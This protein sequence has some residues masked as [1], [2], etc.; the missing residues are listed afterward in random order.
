[1]SERLRVLFLDEGVLGHRT[2]TAQLQATL[3]DNAAVETTFATV[4]PPNK[5]ERLLLRRWRR[6]GDADMFALRW[7]LRWSWRVRRLLKRHRRSVDVA[8]ISTQASALLI[9]GPM[10]RLPC[11]LSIDATVGQFTALEYGG[12][13][14]TWT[15]R[16]QRLL[17][18]L[19]RRALRGAA[20]VVPWTGWNEAALRREYDMSEVRLAT[21]HPGLDGTWWGRAAAARP[22]RDGGPLRVLFVGNE[23]ERKGL[24]TLIDA[25]GRL[26][27]EAILDVVSTDPVPE[28]DLV[29]PHRNVKARTE[30]LRDLYAA[31]DVLALPTRADAVPWVVL[32]AMAAGLPV[33]ASEVGAIGELLGGSGELVQPDDPEQLAAALRRL[34][35]PERR[36]RLG[37]R[38]LERVREN[39][40]SPVQVQRLLE[41]LEE[42]AGRSASAQG[43]GRGRIRRRT[44]VAV[45]AGVVAVAVVAPYAALIPDDE[46]EK[47]VASNLGID[48]KLA[49]QLLARARA[50][51]GDTE[52]DARATAFALAVRDPA[53]IV[54]PDSTREKAISGLLD[55]MLDAPAA[56]LAY[57]ITGADPG[58]PGACAGLVRES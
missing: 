54:L 52:Y 8:F 44:F 19:E 22:A 16:Q 6:V 1:M 36:Q 58:S 55:P 28:S 41:L 13:G 53:A 37:A 46:F 40:N 7:R 27:G 10:R 49:G 17:K 38:A 48:P 12:P 43:R 21:I 29:R 14:D 15:P 51:Y 56:S 47:L 3:A 25:V 39:Y 34:A 4:P 9:R 32:E 11:V 2:L 20:A 45:G 5:V 57:A 24:G 35:D 42:V 31:A 23:V 30:Q 18:R 33:V 26:E 50:E